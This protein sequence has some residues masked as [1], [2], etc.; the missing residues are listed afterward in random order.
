[1]CIIP[2]SSSLLGGLA[3]GVFITLVGEVLVR[4]DGGVLL[5]LVGG[6][7]VGLACGVLVGLARGL[8]WVYTLRR[9]MF[10][11]FITFLPCS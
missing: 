6:V 2:F 3:G 1:M 8:L 9:L 7:L 11:F 10:A 5:G 4:L